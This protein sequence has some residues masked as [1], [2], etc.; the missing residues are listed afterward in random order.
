MH[1]ARATTQPRSP[2]CRLSISPWCMLAATTPKL[3]C[4]RAPPWTAA[5]GSNSSRA[6]NS[7]HRGIRPHRRPRGRGLLFSSFPDPRQNPQ[8]SRACQAIPGRRF[9]TGGLHSSHLRGRASLGAGGGEGRLA[10]AGRGDQ[11][12][13][14]PIS[15]TPCSGRSPLT[16]RATSD[17]K[18]NLVHLERRRVR[19][20]RA[21]GD[22]ER[23]RA[24]EERTG[25]KNAAGT[26]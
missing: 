3:R 13:C 14:A 23:L 22:V 17:P 1:R 12:R 21:I 25:A 26:G 9:R 19:A 18:T 6:R 7:G 15:S 16:K 24:I 8:R 11:A 10:G 2:R 5:I 20:A 4:W